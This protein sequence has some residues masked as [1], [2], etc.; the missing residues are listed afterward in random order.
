MLTAVF[1]EELRE[2]LQRDAPITLHTALGEV[3]EWDSLAVMACMAWFD[4]KLDIKTSFSQYKE[5]QTVADLI[6]LTGGA[7]A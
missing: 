7:I 1:L 3:E 5:L 4:Q 6:A 2:L